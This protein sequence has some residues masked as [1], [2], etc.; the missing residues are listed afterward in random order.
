[1]CLHFLALGR[2]TV[3]SS[4]LNSRT[5][6]QWVT[7]SLWE[8][9]ISVLIGDNVLWRKHGAEMPLSLPLIFFLAGSGDAHLESQTR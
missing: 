4:I 5:G 8:H 9:G 3:T 1:M 6:R 2:W 7:S